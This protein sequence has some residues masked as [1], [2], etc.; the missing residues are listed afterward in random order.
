MARREDQK[1]YDRTV[2]GDYPQE[3]DMITGPVVKVLDLKYA[4]NP[5][6][7]A[8][9][10]RNAGAEGPCLAN[11][12]IIPTKSKRD[13]GYINVEDLARALRLAR[14]IK[15]AFPEYVAGDVIKHEIACGAGRA[16]SPYEALMN[17]WAG[18]PLSAYGGVVSLSEE[19]DVKTAQA[20]AERRPIEWVIAPGYSGDALDVLTK[21]TIRLMEVGPFDVPV[22]IPN[23]EVRDVD[24]GYL[25]GERYKTKIISPEFIEVLF[26]DPTKED[27]DAAILNWIICGHT[28]SNSI[29]VGDAH[30]AYGIG[31]GQTKRVDAAQVALYKASGKKSFQEYAALC[32]GWAKEHGLVFDS[33]AFFPFPDGPEHLA[34]P[35]LR[36][37]MYPTGSN[38]DEEG[39][40]VFR[41][42][43]M[44]VMVPRP[45]PESPTDIERGFL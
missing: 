6:F 2:A 37:G 32:K 24:G 43:G 34:Y 35:G 12:N 17:A 31:A 21:T 1:Q 3:A 7:T 41:K 18:D 23:L 22:K 33:D 8:A 42:N 40:E 39:F 5:G 4:R 28:K 13:P 11:A 29:V 45:N 44:F 27:Y 19:V 10:Y 36:G 9:W 16:D 30:R 14:D 38:K 25:V 26:G 15:E 20:L